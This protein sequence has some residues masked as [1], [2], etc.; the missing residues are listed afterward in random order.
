[1]MTK[2]ALSNLNPG[3]VSAVTFNMFFAL[4]SVLTMS[5]THGVNIA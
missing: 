4:S 5:W 2:A 3:V 1:M